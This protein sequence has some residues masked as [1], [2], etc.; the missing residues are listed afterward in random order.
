MKNEVLPAEIQEMAKGVSV[1]KKNEVQLVL[2]KV[3]DG[4]SK[5]RDQLD[6]II[7]VDENDKVNMKLSNTLRLGVRE[8]RLDSERTFDAKRKEV[9]Q[10]MLSFKT[11]DSLWLKAKQTMQIL[12]KEIEENARWKEETAKRFEVEQKEIKTKQRENSVNKFNPEITRI[13]FENMGDETFNTFLSG[14]ERAYNDKIEAEKAE[15][16]RIEDERIAKEKAD[17]LRNERKQL[18]IPVWEFVP[19]ENR[20]KDFSTL[21]ESEFKDRYEYSLNLKKEN[22]EKIEAQR[23]ENEKLK[24]EAEARAKVEAKRVAK[25]IADAKERQLKEKAD[26]EAQEAI[27]RKEADKRE[28][29]EKERKAKEQQEKEKQDAILRKERE[30]REKVEAELKASK[31][32]ELKK[33]K[34]AE[35]KAKAEKAAQEK[36]EKEALLAPD[37]IKLEKLAK[38]L[39]EITLPELKSDEAK[40]V[41][42]KV[43]ILLNKTS[44]YIK[45][46]SVKL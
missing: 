17:V 37:K 41:L 13:E 2:N 19:S 32:A 18:L 25:E 26:K 45:E 36:S 27:L 9:Q 20:D 30:A 23:L 16:K 42:K 10:S 22:D 3:F 40:E 28:K 46:E 35:D 4:V 11:E 12:T 7:V 34:D 31:D 6:S 39:L 24:S 21:T 1:E 38:E 33:I 14:I 5:M 8:K 43:Q 29:I 44:N 15:E